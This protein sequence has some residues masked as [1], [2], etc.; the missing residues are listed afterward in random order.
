MKR[1][2]YLRHTY[3]RHTYL[4]LSCLCTALAITPSLYAKDQLGTTT[5]TVVPAPA[6]SAVSTPAAPST[7][8]ATTMPSPAAASATST[9]SSTAASTGTGTVAAT[10]KDLMRKLAFA[11]T[12]EI[13]TANLALKKSSNASVKAFAQH[14]IDDHT[15]AGEELKALAQ[16]KNVALPTEP[17]PQHAAASKKMALM[18]GPA[19]DKIYL[20]ESGLVDHRATLKLLENI[21]TQAKDSDLKALAQKMTPTVVAHLDM[22]KKEG[23]ASSS[24]AASREQSKEGAAKSAGT[25]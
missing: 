12:S 10:D 2:T 21:G 6:A 1:H 7:T 17:D 18:S 20:K 14:M 13:A 5:A 4:T 24:N 15:K 8:S 11:N 16:R 19:F 22:V 9:T 25:K 3:L 23:T